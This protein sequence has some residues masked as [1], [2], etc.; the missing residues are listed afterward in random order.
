MKRIEKT[1]FICYRRTNLAWALASNFLEVLHMKTFAGL[2]LRAL[3]AFVLLFPSLAPVVRAATDSADEAMTQIR[4]EAIRADMRFLADDLLEGR[5][6]GTRGHEIAAHF[7]A[8]QFETDG[9]DPAGDAGTYLQYVPLRS[10]RADQQQTTVALTHAGKEERLIFGEDFLASGDAARNETSVDA[11]I[12]YVGYGVTAPEQDYDDYKGVD[13]NG[14]VV[15]MLFGAPQKFPPTLRAHYSSAPEKAANAVAHG[16]IGVIV[17]DSPVYEQIYGFKRLARDL[18]FPSV[19]W[20]NPEGKP[21]DYFEQ[22]RAGVLLSMSGVRKLF[23]G[24]G[25]TL[26][27]LYKTAQ[28]SRPMSFVLPESVKIHVATQHGSLRSPNVVAR[29]RGSDPRLCEEY[30]VYTAHSDHLGIGE[31][32]DGD[33]IY[34]GAVDNASGTAALLE[35]ARAYSQMKPRPRRSIVFV[36]VTG[37]EKGLLGSDYFAH[38]PTVP[39]NA[40][41]ADINMDE[42]ALLW[43]LEDMVLDGQEHSTLADEVQE[44]AARMKLAVAPDAFPEQVFFIRSDQYSFVRQGIPAVASDAGL[45]SSDPKIQPKEILLKWLD[46]VYHTPKDDMNQRLDFDAVTKY[47]RFNFLLGYLIAQK[48][49][50]PTWRPGDFFG[51]K[52]AKK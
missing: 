18:T 40:M 1:V 24:T 41:V 25:K 16:A 29:L 8:A 26:D 32:V 2:Q 33:N 38:F 36:S 7:I 39:K 6:T 46:T 50:R 43:P 17:V 21:N 47:S 14:K 45:K 15:A 44:A 4:P 52:Y 20:L 5:G 28:E 51:D 35:I 13:A 27:E 31:P 42:A 22:I 37:E 49:E 23:D 12:V 9:L 3:L 10:Y 48:A 11:G 30:V 19:R 34:N